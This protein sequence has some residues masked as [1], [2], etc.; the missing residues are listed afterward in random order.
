MQI[1]GRFM[2]MRRFWRWATMALLA[3][4]VAALLGACAALSPGERTI[5]ISEARLSELIGRQFPFNSRY[6]EV[7]D[8][9]I[10]APKVTLLP[11]SNRIAT[12]FNYST[13]SFLLG[14][15][16][17]AGTLDLSY[18]LRFE[19]SDNT[20][21]LADVRAEGVQV[22]GVPPAY[23]RQANRLGGLLTENLLHDFVVHRLSQDDL[24]TAAGW[25]YQPG[26]FKVVPGAL[27]LQLNPVAR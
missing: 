16:E 26:A 20:V 19:P 25:G 7:F 17:F 1:S 10:S 21:R 27:L 8:V 5:K 14:D 6:L 4:M 23:Q 13:G 22:P 24:K 18:A 3:G 12:R 2:S 15:R 9:T 11:E